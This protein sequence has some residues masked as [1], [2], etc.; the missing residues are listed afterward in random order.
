MI[1]EGTLEKLSAAYQNDRRLSTWTARH[2]TLT[3]GNLLFRLTA[4]G[5]VREE[6]KLTDIDWLSQEV[7]LIRFVLLNSVLPA[8]SAKVTLK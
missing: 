4:D 1:H 5:D 8:H 3:K 2:V 6:I 7:H